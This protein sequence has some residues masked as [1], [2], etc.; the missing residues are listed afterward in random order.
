ML[1]FGLRDHGIQYGNRGSPPQ[2][3]KSKESV[4]AEPSKLSKMESVVAKPAEK[5]KVGCGSGEFGIR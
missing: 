4:E 2:K 3:A 5:E 1:P